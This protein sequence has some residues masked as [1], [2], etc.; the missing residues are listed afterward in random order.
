MSFRADAREAGRVVIVSAAGRMTL[1]E[2]RTQVRD[3][4]HVHA[5]AGRNKFLLNLCEVEFIDSYGI[6]ELARCFS[7]VRQSGGSL[8]LCAVN[9][10]VREMLEVTRL[11][12]LFEIYPDEAAAV[13][14]FS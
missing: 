10:K 4:V 11:H 9:G 13:K 1:D 7:V 6:G 14:S 5:V 3:L 8:K 12:L 2:G